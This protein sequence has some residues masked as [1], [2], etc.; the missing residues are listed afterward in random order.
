MF[1][2]DVL[3]IHRK[4]PQE[5]L[6]G[7]HSELFF[8]VL[9]L[10]LHYSIAIIIIT[11]CIVYFCI[12]FCIVFQFIC[13]TAHRV[14]LCRFSIKRKHQGTERILWWSHYRKILDMSNLRRKLCDQGFWEGSSENE[15]ASTGS[16]WGNSTGNTGT[17]WLKPTALTE[18]S[19]RNVRGGNDGH[20]W[21][22]KNLCEIL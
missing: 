15:T 6:E 4:G 16:G 9:I 5:N 22:F 11:I 13:N 7:T 10:F 20:Q 8:R 18:V 1:T 12:M 3:L 2:T 19:E 21:G 14:D 17:P